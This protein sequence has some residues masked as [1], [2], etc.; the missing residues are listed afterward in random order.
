[1]VR[2]ESDP[3]DFARMRDR[4]LQGQFGDR[5]LQ[6]QFG[7][8]RMQIPM[9]GRMGPLRG[10]SPQFPGGLGPATQLLPADDFCPGKPDKTICGPSVPLGPRTNWSIPSVCKEERCND[11]HTKEELL[12]GEEPISFCADQEDGTQCGPKGCL[13]CVH[14]ECLEGVCQGWRHLLA[15]HSLIWGEFCS[16]AKDGTACESPFCRGDQCGPLQTNLTCHNGQCRRLGSVDLP[17]TEETPTTKAAAADTIEKKTTV[18]ASESKTESTADDSKAK[19][20]KAERRKR[21]N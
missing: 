16:N 19:D 14:P 6:G 18:E 13:H 3:R 7:P 11:F 12:S 21:R 17:K 9:P 8:N 15:K 20:K 1:M 10:I 2:G 5:G 4:S